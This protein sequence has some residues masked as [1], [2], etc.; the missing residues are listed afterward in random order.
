[1]KTSLVLCALLALPLIASQARADNL[2][3]TPDQ[4]PRAYRMKTAP[5]GGYVWVDR[6]SLPGHGQQAKQR[7]AA[8]TQAMEDEITGH[9]GFSGHADTP[10]FEVVSH[11]ADLV[12]TAEAGYGGGNAGQNGGIAAYAVKQSDLKPGN[13]LETTL[14]LPV[15]GHVGLSNAKSYASTNVFRVSV[16]GGAW[17]E[18][19]AQG[20]YVTAK[21]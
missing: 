6:S 16:N 7:I 11:H 2:R 18:V 20:K 12:Q 19:R 8:L 9:Q 21:D 17:Q 14:L 13:V 5:N 4:G 3:Q 1:M 15:S 10:A